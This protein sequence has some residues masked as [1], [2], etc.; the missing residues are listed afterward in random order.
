M[1]KHR[2]TSVTRG[3]RSN[4]VVKQEQEQMCFSLAVELIYCTYARTWFSLY[5]HKQVVSIFH[6]LS[7][8]S[9]VSTKKHLYCTEMLHFFLASDRERSYTPL[10]V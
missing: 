6:S 5:L 1:C 8:G 2:Y 7:Q 9:C 4:I 10:S 3:L